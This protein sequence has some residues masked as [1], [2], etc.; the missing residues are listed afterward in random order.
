[1]D[2]LP[3]HILMCF[4][5]TFIRLLKKFVSIQQTCCPIQMI[6]VDPLFFPNVIPFLKLSM[7]KKDVENVCGSDTSLF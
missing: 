1:M 6:I 5:V 3:I 4:Y 2:I 7:K